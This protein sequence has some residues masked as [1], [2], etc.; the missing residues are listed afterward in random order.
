MIVKI[1]IMV[2][3]V[4][5]SNDRLTQLENTKRSSHMINIIEERILVLTCGRCIKVNKQSAILTS[6]SNMKLVSLFA[7]NIMY[8]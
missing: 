8:F 5:Q 2:L 6:I 1:T 4:V 7:I 3:V